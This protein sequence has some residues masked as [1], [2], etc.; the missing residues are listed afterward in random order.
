MRPITPVMVASASRTPSLIGLPSRMLRMSA[1]CISRSPLDPWPSNS[2]GFWP[3]MRGRPAVHVGG[4]LRAV[5]HVADAGADAA[6]LRR[7][8]E[9]GQAVRVLVAHREVVEDVAELR[10]RPHLPAAEALADHR[11]LSRDPVH[12]VEVV[13]QLLDVVVPGEPREERPAADLPLHVAPRRLAVVVVPQ[14]HVA[15]PERLEVG[16]LPDL[17]VPDPLDELEVLGRIPLLGAHDEGQALLPRPSRTPRSASALPPGRRRRA[18]RRRG[19]CPPRPR[20][21]PS[22]GGS[23]AASAA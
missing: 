1:A 5:D 8:G 2:H 10:P 23:P 18:S 20:P 22:R 15:D 4:A 16:Q 11:R 21:R 14:L 17:A 13:D 7:H 9:H 19:A 6:L 3:V 12:H